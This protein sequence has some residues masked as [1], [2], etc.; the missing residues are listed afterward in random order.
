[1]QVREKNCSGLCNLRDRTEDD[2]LERYRELIRIEGSSV[3]DF[4]VKR[5]YTRDPL[6]SR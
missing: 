6:I 1:M 4:G 2:L 5:L 3:A